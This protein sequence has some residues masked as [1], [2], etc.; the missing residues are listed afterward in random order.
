[1]HKINYTK[2]LIH[3]HFNLWL[4]IAFIFAIGTFA[5]FCLEFIKIGFQDSL[6]SRLTTLL[7]SDLVIS[8]RLPLPVK[9]IDSHVDAST[10]K[11]MVKSLYTMTKPDNLQKKSSEV[12]SRLAR[13]TFVPKG[14]PFYGKLIPDTYREIFYSKR[15][16]LVWPELLDILGLKVG[17]SLMIGKQSFE[18]IGEIQNDPGQVTQGQALAPRI[19]LGDQHEKNVGLIS[20]GSTVSYS[21]H[22]KF[23]DEEQKIA[24]HKVL[25]EKFDK[26]GIRVRNAKE[27]GEFIGRTVKIIND[28][29]GLGSF[30]SLILSMLAISFVLNKMFKREDV[31]LKN[32]R[33]LGVPV[34][35]VFAHY[36]KPF[37]FISFLSSL[38]SSSF[39]FLLT[40]QLVVMLKNRFNLDVEMLSFSYVLLFTA[41][42]IISLLV[43]YWPIT[44][45]YLKK[46][47]GDVIKK[48]HIQFGYALGL[49]W[50]SVIA[51]YWT[52]S[53]KLLGLVVAGTLVLGLF[54]SLSGYLF[55]RFL[56][57]GVSS[58]KYPILKLGILQMTR[59]KKHSLIT[60]F[61]LTSSI[62]VFGLI[63]SIAEGLEHGL[64]YDL[65]DKRP[66]MFLFDIQPE[67]KKSLKKLV[68]DH[69]G[70][71]R[72]LAP[73]VRAR[74]TKINGEELRVEKDAI[75]TN[76]GKRKERFLKRGVNLSYQSKLFSS[77]EIIEGVNFFDEPPSDKVSISVEEG[78][79]KLLDIEVGSTMSFEVLGVEVEG[80]VRNIRK[81]NWQSF[82]PNFFIVLSSGHLEEAPQTLVAS[83]NLPDEKVAQFQNSLFDSLPNIS[84]LDVRRVIQRIVDIIS[85]VRGIFKIYGLFIILL[86][87]VIIF[88]LLHLH[89]E[90]RTKDMAF[91]KL[92]GVKG[93]SINLIM[94]YELI[95]L[96]MFSVLFALSFQIILSSVILYEIFEVSMLTYQ[97]IL[98]TTV[99]CFFLLSL[100]LVFYRFRSQRRSQRAFQI[101][102]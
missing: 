82:D 43:L 69:D 7:G 99:L 19:Y 33:Q 66:E 55:F 32:F 26:E 39:G 83:L 65:G 18:I 96:F 6:N 24:G 47:Y 75:E 60:I 28:F 14:F 35:W 70:G 20:K 23:K 15:V 84:S 98:E 54:I 53:W 36:L 46:Y 41:I 10:E 89:W 45:Q 76:E 57:K 94:T 79:A 61:L 72:K 29:L 37:I 50:V 12:K 3:H 85:K 8:S 74:L 22:F 63:N 4:I 40:P 64:N 68:E 25:K 42:S 87:T 71:I 90:D 5:P 51:F 95:F 48:T 97:S 9:E 11:L 17:D 13:L 44:S 78:Y 38:I 2:R 58:K 56:E 52:N 88:G 77:E 86:G 92:M 91:F 73:M 80:E 27:N 30:L 59:F 16:I 101:D 81:I 100:L 34:S 67:Q 93:K 62:G 49:I 21:Y 1:L 102:V 31:S